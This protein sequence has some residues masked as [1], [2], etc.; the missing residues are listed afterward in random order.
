MKDRDNH[1]ALSWFDRNKIQ[2]SWHVN[3]LD[4]L[5]RHRVESLMRALDRAEEVRRQANAG[6]M[7]PSVS[8]Q[9]TPATGST[10]V[11]HADQHGSFGMGFSEI[12]RNAQRRCFE[13]LGRWGGRRFDNRELPDGG[14][15]P[16]GYD[17][18]L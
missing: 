1:Q 18:P 6:A 14:A 13:F 15:S 10:E 17:S 5:E 4:E 2:E 12:W 11:M 3:K 16:A 8:A 7:V 9:V